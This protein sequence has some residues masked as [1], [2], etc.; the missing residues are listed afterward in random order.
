MINGMART[1]EMGRE[2][3]L[4]SWAEN[5]IV[6]SSFRENWKLWKSEFYF[7]TRLSSWPWLDVRKSVKIVKTSSSSARHS[8]CQDP[9]TDNLES[10]QHRNMKPAEQQS[11]RKTSLRVKLKLNPTLSTTKI[12]SCLL[13]LT[14]LTLN[15]QDHHSFGQAE[16]I[17]VV[18]YGSRLPIMNFISIRFCFK[19][20]CH[21]KE[22]QFWCPANNVLML[23]HHQPWETILVLTET[24]KHLP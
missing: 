8:H 19:C 23:K 2:F 10:L 18:G 5:I 13:H 4:I 20:C 7:L 22:V 15:L 1:E 6:A 16:M 11:Q 9:N 21:G 3:N 24:T 12:C 17:M 14:I